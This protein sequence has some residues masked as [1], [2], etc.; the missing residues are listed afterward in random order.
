MRITSSIIMNTFMNNLNNNM[1]N[2]N[3][4]QAQ[5]SSNRRIVHISDDPVGLLTALQVRDRISDIEQYSRNI[6]EANLWLSQAE[7]SMMEINSI[8]TSSY[9]LVLQASSSAISAND[10]QAI[11]AQIGQMRDQVLNAS[12]S[13]MN[14]KY[15]FGGYNTVNAPFAVNGGILYYNGIDMVN[16]DPVALAAQENQQMEFEIASG[17]LRM[18]VSYTGVELLGTGQDNLYDI[19]NRLYNALEADAPVADISDF[20]GILQDKQEE[21]LGMISDIGAR[22]NR[23][24]MLKTR[25]EDDTLNYTKI[26]SQIEDVDQAEVIMNYKMAESVYQ[27]SLNAGANIIQPTLLDF[28]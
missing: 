9:E 27:A 14:S 16:G 23:L 7:N 17:G 1:S 20:A 15:I 18:N 21:M 8:I 25:Y 13:K 6:D 24:D 28:L 26:K 11:A 3:K 2:L 12:N 4:L 22:Y 19:L 5:S 10:K